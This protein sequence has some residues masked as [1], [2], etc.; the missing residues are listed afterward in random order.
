MNKWNIS[1]SWV[2]RPYCQENKTAYINLQHEWNDNQNLIN[3]FILP[4]QNDF[5]LFGRTNIP[6]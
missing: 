3:I 6:E 1:C 4:C 5:K 2:E